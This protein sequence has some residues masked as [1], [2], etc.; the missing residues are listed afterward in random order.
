MLK[1]IKMKDLNFSDLSLKQT[2]M[3]KLK[4]EEIF[5]KK[6]IQ[7]MVPVEIMFIDGRSYIVNLVAYD[8]D[9]LIVDHNGSQTLLYKRSLAHI[10][11][12]LTARYVFG[13]DYM[14]EDRLKHRTKYSTH[15]S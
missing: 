1:V 13:E 4:T 11:P 7:A 10:R 3:N 15:Y 9:S 6:C 5:L 2:T 8:N 12:Q 14:G